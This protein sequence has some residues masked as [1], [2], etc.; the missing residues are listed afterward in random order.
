MITA[1]LLGA[2][3]AA[4]APPPALAGA[5]RGIGLGLVAGDPSGL[6]VAYRPPDASSYLQLAAGWS[7]SEERLSLNGDYLYTITTFASPDDPAL[8]F[9]VYVGLGGRLR[10]GQ[11]NAISEVSRANSL[12]LRIPAGIAFTPQ[13]VAIDVY[14]EV[15]PTLVVL[16]ETKI[17]LGFGIGIRAYPFR[18]VVQIRM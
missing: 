5:A 14:L 8:T 10:L 16:P 17:D 15:A 4:A 13:T 1:L 7:I 2:S 9:P 12:G 18:K 6:S 3:I 11:D